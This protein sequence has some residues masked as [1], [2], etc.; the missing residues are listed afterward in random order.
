M[1][2]DHI[3]PLA[4][5]GRGGRGEALDTHQRQRCAMQWAVCFPQIFNHGEMIGAWQS[6]VLYGAVLT[7][8]DS[9]TQRAIIRGCSGTA[10]R[11][12]YCC[13]TYSGVKWIIIKML[14][15]DDYSSAL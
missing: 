12:L 11:L 3:M 10:A 7:C 14:L 9:F 2:V 1:S 4:P 13:S 8:S 5:S 15:C 6:H